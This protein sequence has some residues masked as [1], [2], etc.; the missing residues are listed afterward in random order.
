MTKKDDW[1]LVTFLVPPESRDAF[2]RYCGKRGRTVSDVLRELVEL[3]IE[4]DR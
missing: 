1:V 2:K 4:K 3:H